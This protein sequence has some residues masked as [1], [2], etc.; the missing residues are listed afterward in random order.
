MKTPRS[1]HTLAVVQGRLV[2]VGGYQG[3]E[4]TSR[5]EVLDMNKDTWEEV[6]GLSTSRSALASAVVN[7]NSLEEEV[8]ES[9]RWQ[10]EQHE[11]Q[12]LMTEEMETN[13]ADS[14]ESDEEMTVE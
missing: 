3:T 9:L 14:E 11:E 2:A 5:V 1:N 4:I 12:V 7:F 8:R 13:T 6:G 10:R